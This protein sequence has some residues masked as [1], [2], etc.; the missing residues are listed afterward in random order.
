MAVDNKVQGTYAIRLDQ[1]STNG[2]GM[3]KA[4]GASLFSFKKASLFG[5]FAFI[6]ILTTSNAQPNLAQVRQV[7]DQTCKGIN[8]EKD[9][10]IVNSVWIDDPFRFLPWVGAREQRAEGQI[11]RLV[12]G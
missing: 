8:V 6:L 4:L 7:E 1:P 10:Y 9:G 3:V 5:F 12:K 11:T 2:L